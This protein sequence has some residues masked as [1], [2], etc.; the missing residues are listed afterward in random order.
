MSERVSNKEARERIDN[1]RCRHDPYHFDAHPTPGI[2]C[3]DCDALRDLLDARRERDEARKR[4]KSILDYCSG[5]GPGGY[6]F[7]K[8]FLLNY[9]GL[10]YIFDAA[11][12]AAGEER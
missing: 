10:T 12:R 7:E 5:E 9:P 3:K 6:I 8:K 1:C 2:H 4:L 11:A